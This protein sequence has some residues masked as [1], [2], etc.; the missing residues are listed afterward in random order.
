M[1][2][3][4]QFALAA[5]AV[6][7]LLASAPAEAAISKVFVPSAQVNEAARTVNLPLL[8]GVSRG[9]TVWF[10]VLDASSGPAAARYGANRAD[11]LNNARNSAAVQKVT[12]VN[13]VIQFPATVDFTPAHV[14]TPGPAGSEFPPVAFQAGAVGEPGYSPIIQLPDGTILNAPHLA[15]AT[16]QADK[17]VSLNTIAG[18]VTHRLTEGFSN[19][20]SVLY[21]STDA[22]DPLAAALED[23][24]LAPQL[25]FAP[26]QGDDSTKSS[27]AAL[28]A[29]I[30]GQ[31]GARNPQR[32]GF[33][34]ALR[35]GLD[36]LNALA[37]TPNQGR[38]SPI[39]DVH[40]GVWSAAAV[41]AGQ[42]VAQKDTDDFFKSAEAGNITGPD[43]GAFRAVG[44]VVNCPIIAE[45]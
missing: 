12:I 44:I 21:V 30:N 35:D 11:K 14:V 22:S 25:G 42:N 33:T 2:L 3:L 41:A 26:G 15:N 13:G 6:I 17:V 9:R 18:R 8:R 36:P 10:V 19:G 31:T 39:W 1:K 43:G 20:K 4:K 34:S 5:T 23:V 38:Y 29:S 45:R 7:T 27:R 40:L 32:Q 28:G 24:T 37:W 16:G